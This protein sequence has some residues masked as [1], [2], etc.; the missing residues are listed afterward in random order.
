M[1]KAFL[2]FS[3]SGVVLFCLDG[4]GNYFAGNTAELLSSANLAIQ[5]L[6]LGGRGII[7][8]TSECED[9]SM[10]H[11]EQRTQDICWSNMNDL[12]L[13]VAATGNLPIGFED[14]L[15]FFCRFFKVFFKTLKKYRDPMERTG[16]KLNIYFSH[17]F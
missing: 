13:L 1:I 10:W 17:L 5:T 12:V 16:P 8:N 9:V 4:S 2:I 7:G 15:K 6:F 11:D 3:R 14:L